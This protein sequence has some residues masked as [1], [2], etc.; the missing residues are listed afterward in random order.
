MSCHIWKGWGPGQNMDIVSLWLLPSAHI[1]ADIL[2]LSGLQ[3]III[4][5]LG[6]KRP[7]LWTGVGFVTSVGRRCDVRTNDETIHYLAGM[8]PGLYRA[9]LLVGLGS[10]GREDITC[11]KSEK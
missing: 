6:I 4:G 3:R 11:S 7:A 2:D 1:V 5:H 8:E 9:R 10:Y